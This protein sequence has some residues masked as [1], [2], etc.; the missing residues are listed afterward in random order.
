[1]LSKCCKYKKWHRLAQ[2][3]LQQPTWLVPEC[4]EMLGENCHFRRLGSRNIIFVR[5]MFGK[6][7]VSM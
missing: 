2:M 4:L 1:M 7:L 6:G 3:L 5:G